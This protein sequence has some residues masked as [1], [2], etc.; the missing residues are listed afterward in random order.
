MFSVVLIKALVVEKRFLDLN[1]NSYSLLFLFAKISSFCYI[2][3]ERILSMLVGIFLMKKN[4]F[5]Y[6]E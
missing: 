5:S 6:F 1:C 4:Y 2:N 3:F